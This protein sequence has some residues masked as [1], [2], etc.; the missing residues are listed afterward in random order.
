V[1]VW[2]Q[3]EAGPYQAIP[4]PGPS[5]QR[6]GK[7][8]C[9]PHEYVRGGTAKLL[10]LFP[11]RTGELRA[12]A[13]RQS[14][15]AVLHPWLK[16]ELQIL[17][18]MLPPGE[19]LDPT[20]PGRRWT[21]WGW[22]T[23]E[24]LRVFGEAP[25]PVR[26]AMIRDNLTGHYSPGIVEWCLH[27]GIVLLYTPLGGSWLNRTP[28]GEQR[29]CGKHRRAESVQRMIV[30][31]ALAGQ[32]LETAEAVMTQLEAVVRG[33][34]RSPTPFEW[35]GKRA[36]RRQRARERR[37]ALGGAAGFTRQPISRRQR[38]PLLP[39]HDHTFLNPSCDPKPIPHPTCQLTH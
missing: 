10:T 22:D 2:C 24:V 15:N 35:G 13:V 26:R 11:P 20:A 25:P 17:L 16:T 29:S 31:R 1:A 23:A 5:W 33:W 30:R 39:Q 37:H 4:Q 7:P 36:E 32:H 3:D 19:T 21:D 18:E 28:V 12:R 38:R 14:T 8:A 34:N 6:Q 27:R 9:R